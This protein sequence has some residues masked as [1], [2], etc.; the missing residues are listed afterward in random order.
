MNRAAFA[1]AIMETSHD[2]VVGLVSA[3]RLEETREPVCVRCALAALGP[4]PHNWM[5]WRTG[6]GFCGSA[7]RGRLVR[8][9]AHL[10]ASVS[11]RSML[12]TA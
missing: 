10:A 9:S 2:D 7:A 12:S 6:N 8:N 4:T 5:S 3:D 1:Q 11:V